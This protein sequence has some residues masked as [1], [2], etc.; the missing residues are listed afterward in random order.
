[1][2]ARGEERIVPKQVNLNDVTAIGKEIAKILL[3]G[4][5]RNVGHNDGGDTELRWHR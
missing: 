5:W 2:E 3:G 4:Q 1:M